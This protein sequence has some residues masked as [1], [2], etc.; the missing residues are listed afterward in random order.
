M[1]FEVWSVKLLGGMEKWGE[2]VKLMKKHGEAVKQ[3][4]LVAHYW[5][6]RPSHGELN[7]A[8]AVVGFRS[9]DDR[10]EWYKTW[11][12]ET[13]DSLKTRQEQHA[14]PY[15]DANSWQMHQYYEA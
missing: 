3:H 2:A 1:V 14:S 12:Q 11:F 5:L 8:M 7:Q 15:L 4:R 9:Y 10:N 6:L 13:P